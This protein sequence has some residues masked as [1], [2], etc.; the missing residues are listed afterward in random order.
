MRTPQRGESRRSAPLW[1]L[2]LVLLA[3]AAACSPRNADTCSPLTEKFWMRA[4]IDQLYLW[5]REVP[6]PDPWTYASTVEYFDV[7]KTPALTASGRPKD[8]FHFTYPTS[9]WEALSQSGIEPGYGVLW[10]IVVAAPP[11][12][13]VAA[14]VDPGSPAAV[15]GI[16]RG[17]TVVAVDGAAVIDGNKDVLNA[18]LFPAAPGET[19]RFTISDSLG[20]RTVSMTSAAIT[21]PCRPSRSWPP[22]PARSVTCS[23]P[24]TSRPPRPS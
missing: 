16:G 4:W 22:P 19:H 2:A 21:S 14:L 13:I 11:R 17:T 8:R 5:Y 15:T 10:S 1:F 23:S 9:E 24:P 6:N 18:G 12:Q 3:L 7:L 20:T